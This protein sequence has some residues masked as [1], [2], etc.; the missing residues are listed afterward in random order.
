MSEAKHE[1]VELQLTAE[2]GRIVACEF[3]G[4][5]R[6]VEPLTEPV[7]YIPA[8]DAPREMRGFENLRRRVV[9]ALSKVKD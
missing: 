7:V 1:Y 2:D 5:G 8:T 3:F 9:R 4:E 6:Q